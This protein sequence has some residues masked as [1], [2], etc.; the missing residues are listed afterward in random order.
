M[1]RS[2][3]VQLTLVTS[4][5]SL[6]LSCDDRQARYCVDQNQN[7]AEDSNCEP[8]PHAGYH[9]YYISSRG[10]FANGAHLSGGGYV[11]PP[12]GY[13]SGSGVVAASER[14]VIGGAGE[15]ASAH[16]GGGEGGGE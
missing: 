8:L 12:G 14:G 7:V 3:A 1:K 9:W 5:A 15:H 4:V 2:H 11:Q 13:L 10:P 16:G 6:L